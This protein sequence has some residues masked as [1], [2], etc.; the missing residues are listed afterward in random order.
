MQRSRLREWLLNVTQ[1]RRFERGS[2]SP[3]ERCPD[4]RE[5]YVSIH[6]TRRVE[7]DARRGG[8]REQCLPSGCIG[9]LL[10]LLK[11]IRIEL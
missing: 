5:S 1:S 7:V 9:C 3:K 10:L 8:R 11:S 4:K 6:I 2:E